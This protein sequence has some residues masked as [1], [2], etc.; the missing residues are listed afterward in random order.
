[1]NTIWWILIIL[2]LL[3]LFTL[4]IR[5]TIISAFNR[6]TEILNSSLFTDTHA[7]LRTL[8]ACLTDAFK[9]H[10]ITEWWLDSGSILG[11]VRHDGFIPH[12]DDIDI[13]VLIKEDTL[14]KL[15]KCYAYI[16][17]T[18][19]QF[20]IGKTISVADA[21][22]SV[23]PEDRTLFSLGIFIDIFYVNE[24]DGIIK[25]NSASMILWPKGYYYT[26]STFPL[27][28]VE[29]E[30]SL[31]NVPADCKKYLF[32]MYGRDCLTKMTIDHLH[33][34]KSILDGLAIHWTKPFPI[35][36]QKNLK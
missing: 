21:Q 14:E 2:V 25:P 36:Y 11:H 34:T 4:F 31:V 3:V 29:F 16:K 33:C 19:P 28:E 8:L 23:M 15:N 1:M 24:K 30:G 32:Q 17:E 27:K 6:R 18:Y 26:E 20:K 7:H 12:D 13:V 10:D 35:Y 5:F 22:L 9:K